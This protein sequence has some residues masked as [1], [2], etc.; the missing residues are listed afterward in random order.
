M[1]DDTHLAV[2][3]QG[4]AAWNEWRAA[5][6]L[7]G[8]TSRPQAYAASTSLK[9]TLPGQIFARRTCEERLSAAPY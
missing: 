2:L 1:A 6:R 4:V 9:S 8:Q 5:T 7:R 3:K